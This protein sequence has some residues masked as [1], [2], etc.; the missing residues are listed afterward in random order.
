MKDAVKLLTLMLTAIKAIAAVKKA[1]GEEGFRFF[2]NL[3]NLQPKETTKPA[4]KKEVEAP[5]ESAVAPPVPAVQ[6]VASGVKPGT[7]LSKPVFIPVDDR[8]ERVMRGEA[9]APKLQRELPPPSNNLMT[10]KLGPVAV[11]LGLI[12]TTIAQFREV[13]ADVNGRGKDYW[14]R[15]RELTAAVL[16]EGSLAMA[17]WELLIGTMKRN[18]FFNGKVGEAFLR[19]C[20]KDM[21]VSF[22]TSQEVAGMI[23]Q[24]RNRDAANPASPYK[25]EFLMAMCAGAGEEADAVLEN[26]KRTVVRM[27]DLKFIRSDHRLVQKVAAMNRPHIPKEKFVSREEIA[28]IQEEAKPV[29]TEHSNQ[30]PEQAPQVAEDTPVAE[31]QVLDPDKMPFE[32]L[33]RATDPGIPVNGHGKPAELDPGFEAAFEQRMLLA[34]AG[35][36]E[37]AHSA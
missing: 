34:E 10:E 20:P 7:I 23:D 4:V 1:A 36:L 13:L 26:C 2:L 8:P 12:K 31:E 24:I 29:E 5:A 6:P 11:A 28:Q 33:D 19:L 14:V 18:L 3:L 37:M 25:L 27:K 9:P 30:G 22:I 35:Q 32:E 16:E 21:L 15:C 17:D